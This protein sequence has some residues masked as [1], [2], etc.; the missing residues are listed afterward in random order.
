MHDWVSAAAL[1]IQ[2]RFGWNSVLFYRH[3]YILHY[4]LHSQMMVLVRKM[5]MT[6]AEKTLLINPTYPVIID[7][8]KRND[9]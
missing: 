1:Q 9:P 2:M 5:T 7:L 3:V 8:V 4:S 6:K